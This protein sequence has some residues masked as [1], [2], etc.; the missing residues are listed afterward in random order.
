[1][2]REVMIISLNLYVC[3]SK[4]IQETAK[5]AKARLSQID[6]ENWQYHGQGQSNYR[7]Q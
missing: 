2:M 6:L 7:N 1:M 3:D 5:D 4:K